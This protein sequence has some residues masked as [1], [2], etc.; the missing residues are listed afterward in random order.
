MLLECH[1]CG[2][3]LDVASEANTVK[4]SYC[5]ISAKLE[6]YK[7]VA[8][9]TPK[10]F[11]PPRH[12]TPKAES[13]LPQQVLV[14]QPAAK[15]ARAVI[16]ALAFSG[17][18]TVAI[19]GFIAWRVTSAVQ[20][21]TGSSLAALEGPDGIQNAVNGALA[22]AGKAAG[23]ATEAAL[24]AATQASAGDTV[25]FLCGGNQTVTLQHKSL[26]LAAGV[27]IVAAGNCTL[28]LV[29]CTVSGTTA[30]TVKNNAS[31]TVEGGSLTGRG[32]AVVVAEN[33]KFEATGGAL[34]TGEST[35]SASGNAEAILRGSSVVGR[36]VAISATGNATVN[37]D[38]AAVEGLVTGKKRR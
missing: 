32:P 28:R 5:G 26:V 34:L 15:A 11:S 19:G 18:M 8:V 1:N 10:D 13:S 30:V 2:A 17:F 12:W 3:P 9:E 22:M 16:R 7:T 6:Q 25:P 20:G 4:C 29:G 24:Q 35:V 36:R 33:G 14:F 38:G 27:P 37:A 21:A 23:V 31:V